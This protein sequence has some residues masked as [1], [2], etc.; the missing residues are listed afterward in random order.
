M[1]LLLAEIEVRSRSVLAREEA[2]LAG[3]RTL[4]G[5]RRWR[6]A[7]VEANT[8]HDGSYGCTLG[9]LCAQLS[10]D[11]DRSRAALASAFDS[12]RQLLIET[13]AR[14]HDLGVLTMDADPHKLGTGL[15]AALQGGHILAQ[16]A[17]NPQPMADALDMA[18]DRID[19]FADR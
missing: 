16:N 17:R 14:L 6:D 5:L 13:L 4:G 18:L 15:L 12:W 9:A 3:V 2:R 19:A 8:L 7:L 11:D 1:T 10:D